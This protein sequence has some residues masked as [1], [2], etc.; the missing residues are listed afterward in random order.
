MRKDCTNMRKDKYRQLKK[1]LRH[2]C[3]YCILQTYQISDDVKI[4][5]FADFSSKLVY[6]TTVIK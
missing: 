1:C 3:A 4:A 6:S 2:E 5:Y